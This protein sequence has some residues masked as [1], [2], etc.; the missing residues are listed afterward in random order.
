M[1]P[2]VGETNLLLHNCCM[3]N[4]A[5][6]MPT[7]VHRMA[8]NRGNL[9][10]RKISHKFKFPASNACGFIS[11][12]PTNREQQDKTSSNTASTKVVRNC[13]IRF[14]PFIYRKLASANLRRKMIRSGDR[15]Y[16][17]SHTAHRI[18][19]VSHRV[20]CMQLLK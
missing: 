17:A 3:I 19:I 5:T 1:A 4:P 12:T 11:I 14:S 18:F 20:S 2:V 8:S 6:L 16:H 13:L 9:E 15:T 7:P 10:I